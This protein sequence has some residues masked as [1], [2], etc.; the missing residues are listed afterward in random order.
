MTGK[1]QKAAAP[2]AAKAVTEP[3]HLEVPNL[4]TRDANGAV[5]QTITMLDYEGSPVVTYRV[6]ARG[7]S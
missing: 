1:K 3:S 6:G 4:T 7:G 5:K 2:V